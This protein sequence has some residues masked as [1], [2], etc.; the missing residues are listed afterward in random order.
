MV[1]NDPDCTEPLMRDMI[2]LLGYDCRV[3]MFKTLIHFRDLASAF[4]NKVIAQFFRA[5]WIS[6]CLRTARVKHAYSPSTKDVARWARDQIRI[7]V[8]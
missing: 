1:Y 2:G 4:P 6:E 7:Q 8:S 3:E 5:D